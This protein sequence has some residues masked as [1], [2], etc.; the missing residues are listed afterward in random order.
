MVY[1]KRTKNKC[2][3]NFELLIATADLREDP[4]NSQACVFCNH[5]LLFVI[6]SSHVTAYCYCNP[7]F[8]ATV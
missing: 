6:E 2:F 8:N 4:H 3:G 1:K 5:C 7:V